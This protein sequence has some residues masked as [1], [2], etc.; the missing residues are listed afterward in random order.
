M[1]AIME[2]FRG[3]TKAFLLIQNLDGFINT[4]QMAMD[5]HIHKRKDINALIYSL[6]F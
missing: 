3:G 6:K 4:V 5:N 1:F 2:T